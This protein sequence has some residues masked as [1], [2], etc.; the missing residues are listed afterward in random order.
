MLAASAEY[1]AYEA[2]RIGATPVVRAT[3]LPYLWPNGVNADG[4]FVHCAYVAPDRIQADYEGFAG[5]SWISPVLTSNLQVPT[6]PAVVSWEWN[7]PGFD[8]LVYYRGAD[9]LTALATEDWTL[10]NSGDTIQIYPFY[11]FKITL[12][13][14]RA[15]AE[16]SLGAAD[17]FTAWAVDV[18]GVEAEEGYAADTN[19][20]GDPLTY[21]QNVVLLG[22]FS[23]V[24][25]IEAAGSV[26]MEAPSDFG[27]LV[28][29]SHS[30]LT[31][32]NRQGSGAVTVLGPGQI[33]Y[34]WTPAPL[35]S[36]GKSSFFLSQ[37]DWY[38]LELII[39]LGWSKGGWFQSGF[40]ED[41]WLGEGFT[42]FITLFH[43]RVKEFGPVTR[44]VGSPNTVEVYAEDF[45]SDC[46]KRRI[47]L[48]A[49]DGTPN[50]LIQG[51][52]LCKGEAVSGST[53][54]D[55]NR[56]AGFESG[57]YD[58]ID[59]VVQS[60]GGAVSLVAGAFRATVTGASKSAYGLWRIVSPGEMFITGVVTFQSAPT[61]PSP[62]NTSF[63]ELLDAAGVPVFSAT[64]DADS[65]V[66]GDYGLGTKSDFNIQAYLEVP[67]PFALWISPVVNGHVRLW[68]N[69]DEVLTYD[70]DLSTRV[71]KEIRFGLQTTGGVGAGEIWT[72]DYDDLK[73]Y[74][75]YYLN[76]FRAYGG[77][78]ESIG[79][80]YI[81]NISQP[82]S[83]TVGAYTQTLTRFADYGMVQF[84]STDPDFKPDGDVTFRVIKH[85]GGVHAVDQIA[86]IL[87]EVGLTPYIDTASFAAA[88]AL[89]PDDII[90]SRFEGGSAEK[91]G[92][93]DI[94][95][96]GLP[97]SDAIKE[98]CSRMMYWVF[99]D[100]GQ[101]RIV[102]YLGTPLTS[103]ALAITASNA[104]ENSQTIDLQNVNAFVTA[105][106]GW[107]S[108]NPALFYVA[109]VQE[110]GGDGTGLDYSWDSP[111]CCERRDV[112][113]AKAD[114]LLQF[115]SAQ[116]IIEPVSMSLAGA[117]LELM[118]DV[119]SLRDELLNDSAQNY[120]VAAKEVGLD[121]G[122]RVTTLRLIRTLEN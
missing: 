109:G 78:F 91:V 28:A 38:D 8:V 105:I 107:Y 119:V 65:F 110:A 5:G 99:M 50:P 56:T 16:E 62:L 98:I 37:Q 35:F 18:A 120:L 46:L 90:H 3:F 102:P 17:D 29:G 19:V 59:G 61:N 115:L 79:T 15:W 101:I 11:Q 43:G 92:L 73:L 117:R 47:C 100:S 2:Q 84:E 1:Q 54:G 112:V 114:L 86:A 97:A 9:D 116:D 70:G 34:T 60:G 72:V 89:V 6:S 81:D 23:V 31:L 13:G 118:T 67:L 44:A 25:D 22:R 104:W 27:D 106:Y 83:K 41:E 96:L 55:P 94:A 113:A 4:Q 74:G 36:P 85:P 95:S 39:E 33:D 21:I 32:N 42:D 71:P 57:N 68:I 64:L 48:P 122:S 63:F 66:Y 76:A 69:G 77:P 12:E 82:D 111:V 75:H 10:V 7:Y 14:Y 121:Q 51:E 88:K 40:L 20:S 30:G 26:S 53:P 45:L 80:V 52:F 103:P 93:K 58:E 24:R 108:R 87:D 49:A